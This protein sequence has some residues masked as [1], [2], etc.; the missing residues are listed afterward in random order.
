MPRRLNAFTLQELLIVMILSGILL[1]TAYYGLR[2]VQ[3]YHH[4]FSASSERTLRY[5]TLQRLLQQDFDQAFRIEASQETIHC[6]HE[7][8]TIHYRF[9]PEHIVREQG[10]QLDTFPGQATQRQDYFLAQ[11]INPDHTPQPI[12]AL[13]FSLTVNEELLT[14]QVYKHYAADQLIT[15]T[16]SSTWQD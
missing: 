1:A 10:V 6:F 5:Q 3:Q 15:L 13:V 12:S 8:K 16:Q 11:T 7:H 2:M 4:Q 9:S 14:F